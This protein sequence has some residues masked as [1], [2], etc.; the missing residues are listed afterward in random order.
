MPT[1]PYRFSFG[2]EI[3]AH[4]S[5]PDSVNARFAMELSGQKGD[6]GAIATAGETLL[7]HARR[8][9]ASLAKKPNEGK[10]ALFCASSEDTGS[11]CLS[12]RSTPTK[13]SSVWSLA[14]ASAHL[15][16]TV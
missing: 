2:L 8:T 15:K 12:F 3:E 5:A 7:W 9:I 16:F 4:R 13:R 14:A 6:L 11:Q 10:I 1:A